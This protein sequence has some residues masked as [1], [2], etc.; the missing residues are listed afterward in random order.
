MTPSTLAERC[1][2]RR[3]AA[4]LSQE[5]LGKAC[6]VSGVAI[7]LIENGTTKRP[8]NILQLATALKVNPFW[9]LFGESD[10]QEK[11]TPADLG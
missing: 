9:L 8:R 7:L 11:E 6:G 3:V 4:G 10:D 2:D 1:K 5:Q